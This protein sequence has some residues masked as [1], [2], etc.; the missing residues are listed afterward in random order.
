MISNVLVEIQSAKWKVKKNFLSHRHFLFYFSELITKGTVL[1][2]MQIYSYI[3][4]QFSALS[5]L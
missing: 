4:N 3:D 1:S 2:D 5:C